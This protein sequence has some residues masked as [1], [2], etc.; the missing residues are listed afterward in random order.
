MTSP[1]RKTPV[2]SSS[3]RSSPRRKTPSPFSSTA[4]TILYRSASDEN[5]P[6]WQAHQDTNERASVTGGA[7]H[8]HHTSL[9]TRSLLAARKSF[10]LPDGLE[11]ENLV[12]AA[13]A[14]EGASSYSRNTF[15]TQ[16]LKIDYDCSLYIIDVHTVLYPLAI[17]RYL[18]FYYAEFHDYSARDVRASILRWDERRLERIERE[19]KLLQ[20]ELKAVR[21]KLVIEINF[22]CSC[23]TSGV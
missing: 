23:T 5:L 18:I 17:L 21:I 2:R 7:S 6:A 15:K 10:P 3:Q 12:D 4:S 13:N 11:W 1:T 20:E 8:L 14:A 9:D 16:R 22:L 19:M